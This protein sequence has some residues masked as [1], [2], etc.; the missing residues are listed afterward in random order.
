MR[1]RTS[2][3]HNENDFL[4]TDELADEQI[5]MPA[6]DNA[7]KLL[8]LDKDISARIKGIL[9]HYFQDKSSQ[10]YTSK[11]SAREKT[12]PKTEVSDAHRDNHYIFLLTNGSRKL[13]VKG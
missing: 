12:Q 2:L 7:D 9:I 4:N 10:I 1:Y 3:N 8:N 13:E 6:H 11:F 5:A